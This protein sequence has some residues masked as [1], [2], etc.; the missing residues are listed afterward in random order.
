MV[1]LPEIVPVGIRCFC[2]TIEVEV[3]IAPKPVERQLVALYLPVFSG[4]TR[5][6]LFYYRILKS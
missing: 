6:D 4:E 2:E 5:W 1:A 3:A